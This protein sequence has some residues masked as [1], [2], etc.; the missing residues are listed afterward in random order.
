MGHILGNMVFEYKTSCYTL[1]LNPLDKK[2]DYQKYAKVC[3]ILYY[4]TGMTMPHPQNK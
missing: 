4:L 3:N 1:S 2:L